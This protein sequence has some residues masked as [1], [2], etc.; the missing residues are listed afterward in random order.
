MSELSEL[1]S[2][3]PKAALVGSTVYVILTQRRIESRIEA[4]ALQIGVAPRKK[5]ASRW[6]GV[7]LAFVLVMF[8]GCTITRTTMPD[9]TRTEVKDFHA[10][11]NDVQFIRESRELID[12]LR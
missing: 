3:S 6:I 8:A 7:L 12:V 10:T 9:G 11:T 5:K 1:I 4:I 2:A